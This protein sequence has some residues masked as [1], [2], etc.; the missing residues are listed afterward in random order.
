MKAH[1]IALPAAA[2][3]I[4]SAGP[5]STDEHD[6]DRAAL[7][8]QSGCFDCHSVDEKVVGPAY[9]DVAARY[10]DD[11]GARATLIEKVKK[12]GKGNWTEVTDGV[13]M[14]PHWGRLTPEEIESLVDWVLS[15]EEV[16]R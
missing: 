5:A 9:R 14:P 4:L 1:W 16:E 11:E 15:L 12:G 13:L 8:E 3:L 10:R 7:A 2:L 6:E